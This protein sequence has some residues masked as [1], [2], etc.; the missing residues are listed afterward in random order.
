MIKIAVVDDE[1]TVIEEIKKLIERFLSSHSLDFKLYTFND[2]K[3]LL[4]NKESYDIIFLD[5]EMKS[6]D[7]ID[8]AIQI[9]NYDMNVP[10]VYITSFSKYWRSAYQVHAF[11][12][13]ENPVF[14]DIFEKILNDLLQMRSE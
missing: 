3:D 1:Q 4:L 5:I 6:L 2:G 12:F 11:G 13:I 10:I 14:Y 7:G 8:T 9:R